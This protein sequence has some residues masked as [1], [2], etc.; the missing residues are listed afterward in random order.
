M[1]SCSGPEQEL[2]PVQ[3]HGYGPPKALWSSGPSS[4]CSVQS[5]ITEVSCDLDHGCE[6]ETLLATL[7]QYCRSSAAAPPTSRSAIQSRDDFQDLSKGLG[8]AA[9]AA[10]LLV[11]TA[12]RTV[13]APSPYQPT[14]QNI[15]LRLKLHD[16]EPEQLNMEALVHTLSV[17]R[18]NSHWCVRS[19]HTC[20][21]FGSAAAISTSQ[22]KYGGTPA[23]SF[24]EPVSMI[25]ATHMHHLT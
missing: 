10:P 4:S 2:Q 14:L 12:C 20:F 9:T 19:L 1:L 6:S 25:Q 18:R 7:Q 16:A 22:I 17:E 24:V 15:Q 3:W 21:A 23:L 8:P 13:A 11:P 5:S